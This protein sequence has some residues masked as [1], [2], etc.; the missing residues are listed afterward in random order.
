VGDHALRGH[1]P[2]TRPGHRLPHVA[3]VA[4]FGTRHPQW[5]EAVTAAVVPRE[6]EQVSGE[7]LIEYCRSR[8]AAFKVPKHVEFVGQLPKNASG[9]LLKRELREAIRPWSARP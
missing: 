3:E 8:P 9:K 1:V 5:I 6:G 2:T 7:E 4:V